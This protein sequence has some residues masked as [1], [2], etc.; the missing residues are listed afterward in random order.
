MDCTEKSIPDFP[1]SLE[2]GNLAK[3][4]LRFNTY[5]SIFL[6]TYYTILVLLIPKLISFSIW[7]RI[8][9][10]ITVITYIINGHLC[11]FYSN[12]PAIQELLL[13]YTLCV[14]K[15]PLCLKSIQLII[16]IVSLGGIIRMLSF[17]H[18]LRLF[19][20]ESLDNF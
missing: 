13:K 16:N 20:W 10:K 5:C 3:I 8:K 17:G 1:T 6:G 2:L 14:R 19:S 9:V 15:N 12:Q 7:W 4:R 11:F 18:I